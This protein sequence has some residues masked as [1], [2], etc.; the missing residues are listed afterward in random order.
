MIRLPAL[1]VLILWLMFIIGGAL[2][3]AH[4]PDPETSEWIMDDHRLYQVC[5]AG[6]IERMDVLAGYAGNINDKGE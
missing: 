3:L 6:R 1:I 5:S 2:Y 4:R